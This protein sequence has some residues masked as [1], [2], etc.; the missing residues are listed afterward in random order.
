LL[1]LYNILWL[2][3][4]SHQDKLISKILYDEDYIINADDLQFV[5]NFK[6]ENLKNAIEFFKQLPDMWNYIIYPYFEPKI[7]ILAS[8]NLAFYISDL[9]PENIN[10]I[11]DASWHIAKS[12]KCF[13]NF[14]NKKLPIGMITNLHY[15]DKNVLKILAVRNYELVF[16][17]G[18][19][20]NYEPLILNKDSKNIF[21]LFENIKLDYSF[22]DDINFVIQNFLSSLEMLKNNSINPILFIEAKKI[23]QYFSDDKNDICKFYKKFI[24]KIKK[25]YKFI[26]IEKYKNNIIENNTPSN[27]NTDNNTSKDD[28]TENNM[29]L[30]QINFIDNNIN[31]KINNINLKEQDFLINIDSLINYLNENKIQDYWL[32][33][34]NIKLNLE[35]KKNKGE[36]D[37][38]VYNEFIQNIYRIQDI[39]FLKNLNIDNI[40]YSEYKN[41]IKNI[42]DTVKID[43]INNSDI[44]KDNKKTKQKV[45][46]IIYLKKSRGFYIY[47][48]LNDDNGDGNYVYPENKNF[49]KGILDLKAFQIYEKKDKTILKLFMKNLAN[50]LNKKSG[51]SMMQIDIYIDMNGRKGLGNTKLL[52]DRNAFTIPENAWEYCISINENKS[53]LYLSSSDGNIYPISEV[54][55]ITDKTNNNI[56]ISIPKKTLQGNVLLWKYI[57]LACG[58]SNKNIVKVEKEKNENNFGGKEND[59]QSNI[60]DIILPSNI[61]QKE[62]LKTKHNIIEIPAIDLQN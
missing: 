41:I 32:L 37:T 30:E 61:K 49:E 1:T 51:F 53:M 8:N 16:N 35:D 25:E 42:N 18:N 23:N 54:E 56:T 31:K 3:N 27:K 29:D 19:F 60:I 20:L 48:S 10:L 17:K 13:T 22:S 57:V 12:F 43:Y 58:Y 14:F 38:K 44:S 26:D 36:I 4:D 47:D 55:A 50:P 9:L 40:F 6:K 15:I 5:S 24:N 52:P 59:F 7:D 11:Y 28:V 39:L 46:N 62:L 34:K 21:M 33:I 2:D 45:K